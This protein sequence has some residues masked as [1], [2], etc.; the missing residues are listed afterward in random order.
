M[1]SWLLKAGIQGAISLAPG[2]HRLNALLQERVTRSLELSDATFALKLG[3]CAH[4]LSSYREAHGGHEPPRRALELGTGWYPIVPVGLALAGIDEVITA[5]ITSL[6][7]PGRTRRMLELFAAAIDTGRLRDQLREIHPARAETVMAAARDPARH[8]AVADLLARVGVR[9]FVGE[10]QDLR[11]A[12]G[13]VELLVSNNTLEH[14]PPPALE[15]MLAKL[16]RLCAPGAVMD[17]FIDISDHYAHFDHSIT[18]FNY[19]RYPAGV[20]RLLNNRLQYQSRLRV[21]DYLRLLERAG[22]TVIAQEPERGD[23]EQLAQVPLAHPFRDYA[24]EDLLVLRIWITAGAR[25]A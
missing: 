4:H 23:P 18:E 11:L 21:S 1:P 13:S 19:L 5:D 25:G 20:W 9:T 17:H 24:R 6:M 3:Q 10:L 15:E 2:R 12:D 14:V 7:D 22:F 16:W 8:E